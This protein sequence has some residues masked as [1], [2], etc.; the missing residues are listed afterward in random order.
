VS[1]LREACNLRGICTSDASF[2]THCKR[3]KL[4]SI[5][6]FLENHERTLFER[7]CKTHGE[8]TGVGGE[9]ISNARTDSA[10]LRLVHPGA[11]G[12]SLS[13]SVYSKFSKNT[14]AFGRLHYSDFWGVVRRYF[15][16]TRK[17]W[18]EGPGSRAIPARRDRLS[19]LDSR[20]GIGIPDCPGEEKKRKCK[21]QNAK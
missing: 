15:C 4:L 11:P 21:M 19:A 1:K 18:A 13:P 16:A 17:R 20:R 5:V 8:G 12:S 6:A 7:R 14:P 10:D 3:A 2:T 9:R